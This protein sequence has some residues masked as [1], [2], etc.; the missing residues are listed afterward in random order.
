MD[1]F[2]CHGCLTYGGAFEKRAYSL[3]CSD[4]TVCNRKE[5]LNMIKE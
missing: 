1:V 4:L 3:K 2:S 5:I